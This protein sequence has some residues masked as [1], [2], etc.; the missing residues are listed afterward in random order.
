MLSPLSKAA[1][2]SNILEKTGQSKS[3]V[4]VLLRRLCRNMTDPWRIVSQQ[5]LCTYDQHAYIL[6]IHIRL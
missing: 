1:S 2:Y 3:V 6:P 4:R 5:V